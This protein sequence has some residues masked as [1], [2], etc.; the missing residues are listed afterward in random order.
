M[1]KRKPPKRGGAGL[2]V[3]EDSIYIIGKIHYFKL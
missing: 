2:I 1:D 3:N